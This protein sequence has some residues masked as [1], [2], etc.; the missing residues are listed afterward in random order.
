MYLP[1]FT[2]F[3][4][5]SAVCFMVSVFVIAKIITLDW[6]MCRREA[7]YIVASIFIG[8]IISIVSRDFHNLVFLAFRDAMI[9]ILLFLYFYIIR[10]YNLK[11]AMILMIISSYLFVLS[12]HILTTSFYDIFPEF[13]S[14]FIPHMRAL[15]EVIIFLP[16]ILHAFLMVPFAGL[17]AFIAVKVLKKIRVVMNQSQ[18]LQTVFVSV[19]TVIVTGIVVSLSW[20]R[21]SGVRFSFHDR[22]FFPYDL[23]MSVVIVCFFILASYMTKRHEQQLKEERY[24][25]LQRYTYELEQQQSAMRKFKHDYQNILLSLDSFIKEKKWD[26]LEEYY[27]S[28]V[29]GASAIITSNEFALEALSKIKVNEV[30][31]LLTAKLMV[32]QNIGIDASFEAHEEIDH[33]PI[34]S[35]SLV[36]MLGIILDNAIEAVEE[37]G[38]G[39]IRA[40][41]Y[42]DDTEIVFLVQNSCRPNLKL[43]EIEQPGFSTKGKGRGQGL[44]NLAEISNS[45]PNVVREMGISNDVFTQ[46]LVISTEGE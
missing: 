29:K 39:S 7:V 5:Y 33:I 19:G 32:A 30:K 22:T 20:M 43:Q 36:R 40:A 14:H 41:Y 11:K 25:G 17:L 37:L 2:L 34:D 16:E 13:T 18:L 46:K 35:V 15:G 26:E 21:I 42:M 38:E 31:S 9:F 45:C 12:V 4:F 3:N 28:K 23:M 24:Q 27:D 10:F 44:R 8:S 1:S 6:K